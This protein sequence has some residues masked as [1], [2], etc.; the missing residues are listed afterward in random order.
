MIRNTPIFLVLISPFLV[1]CE[2]ENLVIPT[3]SL[4]NP[5]TLK[6]GERIRLYPDN[7]QVGFQKVISDSRCPSNARCIWEG[8]ADLQLW[9]L[10]PG[11]DTVYVKASIRG[12][13]TKSNTDGH[14]AVDALGYRIKVLQLDPYP[15]TDQR[16]NPSDYIATLRVSRL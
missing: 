11:L 5:F 14:V 7:L 6:V 8:I 15:K 9:L 10:K 1:S 12:Y 13:V 2:D 4:D 16:P 3:Q